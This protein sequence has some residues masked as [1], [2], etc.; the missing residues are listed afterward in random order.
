MKTL[1]VNI[2]NK[3]AVYSQRGG[4]IVCGNDDYQIKFTFDAEWDAY[5][6]KTARFSWNGQYKD[7]DFTGDTVTVPVLF[8]TSV[9]MVGVY[10]GDLSTTT[11]ARIVC[12][13]SVL[14][15]TDTAA[16]GSGENYYNEAKA[17]AERAEAAAETAAAEAAQ[18]FV[19]LA[20]EKNLGGIVQTPGDSE[21]QVMSQKAVTDYV[22]KVATKNLA[23]LTFENARIIVSNGQFEQILA[24]WGAVYGTSYAATPDYIEVTGGETY[25][26]SWEK[27]DIAPYTYIFMYDSEK[28]FLGS[29]EFSTNVIR[30]KTVTLDEACRYVRFHLYKDG[31]PWED[32]PYKK[33][34]FELGEATTY[35]PPHFIDPEEIDYSPAEAIAENKMLPLNATV[36]QMVDNF[37]EG[38]KIIYSFGEADYTKLI[39]A[40]PTSFSTFVGWSVPI[41]KSSLRGEVRGVTMALAFNKSEMPIVLELYDQDQKL[42]KTLAEET[43]T[44]Y[45]VD[46]LQDG[47]YA[48]IHTFKCEFDKASIP[49]DAAYLR[50]YIPNLTSTSTERML[51]GVVSDGTIREEIDVEFAPL[52]YTV[53]GDS[54]WRVQVKGDGAGGYVNKPDDTFIQIIEKSLEIN[55][56]E[57]GAA[58][59]YAAYGL[60]VLEFNGNISAMSKDVAVDLTYKYGDRTGSCTL[61]WQGSSS[62]VY[63]KKNYTVKFDTAFE[64]K[65]GWGEQKKYCLKANYIDFSHSRNICC[66]KLWGEVVKHRTPENA[67]LNALPNAGAIDGFPICVVINGEY[68]GLYT[69]NIPKDGWMFGMG[70]GANEAILCADASKIGACSFDALATLNGDFDVEYAPDEDNTEWIKTSVNRLIQACIN[71]N[72]SDLDTTIAQYLDWESAIDYYAFCLVAQNYD[73]ITKNYLLVTYDGVKWFF[74]AYDMDSTFGLLA[75]GKGF[76]KVNGSVT[77]ASAAA[78]HRVFNL[79]KTY[80]A[81]ELKARYNELVL[82]MNGALS[83]ESITQT[84]LNFAGDIPKALLDEEVKIWPTLPSTSVNN[85]SQILDFNRRRRAYI[86]SQIDAL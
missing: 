64:A 60:P 55:A 57:S 11:R 83:E 76:V 54:S 26:L 1:N 23:D 58:F 32:I 19:D 47:V 51:L 17:A 13:P 22:P 80:K 10:A 86:D 62:I 50:V 4:E 56:T 49:T 75:D 40:V 8:N 68:K 70:D 28:A 9:L 73:G 45:Q 39:L 24:G 18:T 12:V 38:E 72:G 69:F 31:T 7:V 43:V 16:P 66:A 61:K 6:S 85:V 35:V 3:V 71:S 2:T 79:I 14:C 78:T 42:I 5:S 20:A 46:G 29:I 59:D 37:T 81:K 30:N 82:A 44:A 25:T 74:S 63:P 52:Y 21:T 65:D 67:N 41:M 27:R 48:M 33:L 36:E 53:L 15:G 34:Q 77:V 84:F